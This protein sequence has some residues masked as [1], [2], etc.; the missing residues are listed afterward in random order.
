MEIA[1]ATRDWL[2]IR[3]G[4]KSRTVG[5]SDDDADRTGADEELVGVLERE[6]EADRHDHQLGQAQPAPS[7]RMPQ[8]AVLEPA[9][10]AAQDDHAHAADPQAHSVHV[11]QEV[12][13]H[14]AQGHLLGVREVRDPGGAVDQAEADA[15]QG[16][17]QAEPDA[18]DAGL[19]DL[20]SG[21]AGTVAL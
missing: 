16:Q 12:G 3:T 14:A 9:A 6:R 15:G 5:V 19:E 7:Q 8:D 20:R 10:E 1:I 21:R 17:Q 2:V 13:E 4:P 18:V 11:D